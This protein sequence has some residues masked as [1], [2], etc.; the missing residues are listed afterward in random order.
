MSSSAPRSNESTL[1]LR[2]SRLASL[3]GVRVLGTGS[4]VPDRVVTNRDLAALGYDDQWILQRTGIRQRRYAAPGMVTSDLA[5]ESGRRCIEQAGVNRDDIDVVLVAT[6]TPDM[7]MPAT[8]S[9]VQDRLGLSALAFDIEAACA[10]FVFA[11]ITGMQYVASGSSQL[12]LIIGADCN[13]RVINPADKHTYPLFGDGAG[14]VLIARGDRDQGLLSYAVGSD[15]AG[16]ELVCRAMGGSRL[17]YPESLDHHPQRFLTM[18]GRPIFK[19]AVRI[20]EET[21]RQ[22]LQAARVELDQIALVIL[23]QANL[24]II[25]AAATSLGIAPHRMYNNVDR[26]GN[27]SSASVALALDEA[28]REGRIRRGDLVLLSGFGGG[29]AWGTTLLRW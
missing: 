2:R 22:V 19:W 29:L 27:T 24:R 18:E 6:C 21:I 1:P 23:H 8:A 3:L 10:G 28:Y 5:I 17:P 7:P 14:A 15:G 11:M 20:L 4:S 13:S 12:A 26:Y 25:D 16:S 9:V